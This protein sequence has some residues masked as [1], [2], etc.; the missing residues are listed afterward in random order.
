MRCGT[1][2]CVIVA[3]TVLGASRAPAGTLTL[4]FAIDRVLAITGAEAQPVTGSARVVLT[5]VDEMGMITEAAARGSLESFQFVMSV[6]DGVD[7]VIFD[8]RLEDPVSSALESVM[9][10]H[11]GGLM[12]RFGPGIVLPIG[13]MGPAASCAGSSDSAFLGLVALANVGT[14]GGAGVAVFFSGEG[15]VLG[16]ATGPET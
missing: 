1:M 12:F 13:C 4:D 15:F 14:P 5:G 8:I 7:R 10:E 6:G 3:S 2:I 11:P 16:T 9:G